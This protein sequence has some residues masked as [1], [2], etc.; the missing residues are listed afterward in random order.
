MITVYSGADQRKHQGSASLA[1]VRGFTGDGGFPAQ[2]ASKAEMFPF[3]DVI[4]Y[5]TG[6][7]RGPPLPLPLG[8]T[9]TNIV[10]TEITPWMGNYI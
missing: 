8:A 2:M 3:D 1:F 10:S 6:M 5:Y 9:F 4:M 7:D